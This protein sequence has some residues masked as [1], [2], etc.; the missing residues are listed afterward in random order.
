MAVCNVVAMTSSRSRTGLAGAAC[1]V[2]VA[3]PAAA[4]HGGPA[5]KGFVAKVEQVRPPVPG[6]Q[7]TILGGDERMRMVNRSGRTIV[8]EGYDG[9]PYLRLGPDGLYVNN[10]SPAVWLNA[11]RLGATPVPASADPAAPP[12]WLKIRS[13]QVVEWHEH[14]AQWMSTVPPPTV[15]RSPGERHFV[16]DWTVPG[17]VD[18]TPLTIAGSL[19]YVP[20]GATAGSSFPWSIVALVG[21]AVIALVVIGLLVIARRRLEEE[22][23]ELEAA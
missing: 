20:A 8:L 2:L 10:K 17:M 19:E 14:R 13:E 3:V 23:E 12:D 16:F 22:E 5:P 9:E 15:L 4:A 7:V 21:T 18:G 11:D 6:L 1:A